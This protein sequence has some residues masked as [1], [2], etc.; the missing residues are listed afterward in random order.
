MA[1]RSLFSLLIELPWWVSVLA[2]AVVYFAG[3]VFKPLIGAAAALPFAGVALY[4][5]W[6]RLRRGRSADPSDLLRA[7]RT[8]SPD[9]MRAMLTEAFAA[10]HYE[11]ADA[12]EGDLHLQRNG[13][14]TVVRYRRWR[15]QSTS[16]AA[17]KELAAAVQA[18]RADHG[19]YVTAGTVAEPARRQADASGIT[20]L[21]ATALANLVARTRSARRAVQ[22]IN[23]EAVSQ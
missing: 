13:Y 8:A 14:V 3:A 19:M 22:R 11:V 12:A 15:A 2:A 1:K 7:F 20:L 6:L 9:E 18:R 4:V 10:Q 23:K 21:D 16:P 17:L 5:L